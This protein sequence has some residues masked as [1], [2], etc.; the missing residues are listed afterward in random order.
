VLQYDDEPDAGISLLIVL[1]PAQRGREVGKRALA[2]FV[3]L[4]GSR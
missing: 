3:A 4:L 1:D 2:A